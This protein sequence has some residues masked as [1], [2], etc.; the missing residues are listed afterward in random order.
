MDFAIAIVAEGRIT[1][2]RSVDV[3]VTTAYFR[4]Y[5]I[6]ASC[7]VVVLI[8]MHGSCGRGSR[9]WVERVLVL[10]RD[11]G[12]RRSLSSLLAAFHLTAMCNACCMAVTEEYANLLNTHTTR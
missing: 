11:A 7:I 12:G 9:G 8:A 4:G 3:G 5:T 6:C 1:R 2:G 10:G